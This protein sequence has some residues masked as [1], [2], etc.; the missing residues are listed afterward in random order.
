[1]I[2]CAANSPVA[3]LRWLRPLSTLMLLCVAAP[4]VPG[5][6]SEPDWARL[7][8]EELKACV[9][10]VLGNNPFQGARSAAS[11]RPGGVRIKRELLKKLRRYLDANIRGV[12]RVDGRPLLLLAGRICQVGQELSLPREA[13][14]EA[15]AISIRIK[16]LEPGRLVL[17]LGDGVEEQ[18]EGYEEWAYA[19]SEFMTTKQP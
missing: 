5:M 3:A 13:G 16:A 18:E 1:M 9:P 10:V 4:F 11:T 7:H 2:S 19:M 8:P 6:T 15:Q 12:V 17:L 14:A